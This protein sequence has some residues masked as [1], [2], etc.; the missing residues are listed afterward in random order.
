MNHERY[1]AMSFARRRE[2]Y[3]SDEE[4]SMKTVRGLHITE[5]EGSSRSFNEATLRVF[6]ANYLVADDSGAVPK[7]ITAYGYFME[8][9]TGEVHGPYRTLEQALE[10]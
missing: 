3:A 8:D 4:H 10:S 7:H 5:Q 6:R 2:Q 9:Q 1:M